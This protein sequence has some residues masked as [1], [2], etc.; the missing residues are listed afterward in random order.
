MLRNQL[1]TV[2]HLSMDEVLICSLEALK[3]S[4]ENEY[5][6]IARPNSSLFWPKL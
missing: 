6:D 4:K 3:V 2:I 1:L 5:Y